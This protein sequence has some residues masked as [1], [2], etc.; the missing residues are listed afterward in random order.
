M[1]ETAKRIPF[2]SNARFKSRAGN[3]NSVAFSGPFNPNSSAST[4][5]ISR[6]ERSAPRGS[7]ASALR[8]VN[9]WTPAGGP[10]QPSARAGWEKSSKAA[11]PVSEP[12]AT[13]EVRVKKP[14]RF[15]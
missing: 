9:S 8:I 12:A 3:P 1:C 10:P 13:R 14:R 6:R 4:M 5:P 11:E 7:A 15:M 2:S